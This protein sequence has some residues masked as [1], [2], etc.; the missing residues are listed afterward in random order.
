MRPDYM[1]KGVDSWQLIG[2]KVLGQLSEL[3]LFPEEHVAIAVETSN[4]I[5]VMPGDLLS[6]VDHG[7]LSDPNGAVLRSLGMWDSRYKI[8]RYGFIL[9]DPDLQIVSSRKGSWRPS[10]EAKQE[11]LRLLTGHQLGLGHDPVAAL[12]PGPRPQ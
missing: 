12:A 2:K 9:L 4:A 1:P 10:E 5:G 7:I 11:F 6:T 8:A 3:T